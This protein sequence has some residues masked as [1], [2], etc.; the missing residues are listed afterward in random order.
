MLSNELGDRCANRRFLTIF[1]ISLDILTHYTERI[2]N[3]FG[4]L[5]HCYADDA[6]VYWSCSLNDRATLQTG[7]FDNVNVIGR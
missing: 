1:S 2:I 7:L 4:L 6:Q 5:H 3:S